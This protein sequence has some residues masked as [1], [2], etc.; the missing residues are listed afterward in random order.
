MT[1]KQKDKVLQ[2]LLQV[3]SDNHV[4]FADVPSI[5][6][7]MEAELKELSQQQFIRIP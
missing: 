2:A 4:T 5:I 6:E 1:Q 7:S 3:L